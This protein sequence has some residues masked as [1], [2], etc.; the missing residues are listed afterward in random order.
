M[1][2]EELEAL[3]RFS[4]HCW[5]VHRQPV[6]EQR[7]IVSRRSSLKFLWAA[8]LLTLFSIFSLV[9]ELLK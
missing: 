7:W 2:H 3:D 6:E 5:A 4:T 1:T 9:G 8:S